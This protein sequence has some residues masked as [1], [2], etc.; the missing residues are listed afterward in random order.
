MSSWVATFALLTDLLTPGGTPHALV[1]PST[2]AL[3]QAAADARAPLWSIGTPEVERRTAATETRP[4]PDCLPA[5]PGSNAPNL[6]DPGLMSTMGADGDEESPLCYEDSR[7]GPVPS[8][9][10]SGI[11]ILSASKAAVHAAWSDL[12]PAISG[13]IPPA[14]LGDPESGFPPDLFRPPR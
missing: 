13:P 2:C 10:S 3:Q 11:R 7:C 12:P 6:A 14:R 4:E 9:R 8:E 5:R 1:A